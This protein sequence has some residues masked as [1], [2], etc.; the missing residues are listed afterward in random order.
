M[1]TTGEAIIAFCKECVNSNMTKDRENCGGEYVMATK[2]PCALMKYRIKGRA[3]LSAIRK[4]CV[5]CAG[6]AY[7]VDECM[8][9]T[10]PLYAFR[11]GKHPTRAGKGGNIA[12]L[13]RKKAVGRA[14]EAK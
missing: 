10:C 5:E 1:P 14:K 7:W 3:K 12:N 13:V 4:N 8:T 6:G 11:S 9:K 2:K